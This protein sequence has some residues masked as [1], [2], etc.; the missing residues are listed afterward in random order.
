MKRQPTK[1]EKVFANG[2]TDKG[3]ISNIYKQFILLNIKKKNRLKN[4]QK[5]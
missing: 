5:N 1:G 4:G 3:L 2:M